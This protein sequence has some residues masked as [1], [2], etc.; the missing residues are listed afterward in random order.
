M[1]VTGPM[2]GADSAQ[3][4]DLAQRFSR[5]AA[6]L[7]GIDVRLT[8]SINGTGAWQ[9]GDAA[10][11]RSAWN[12]EHRAY[13][14]SSRTALTDGA[15]TLRRNAVEQDKASEGSGGA[16]GALPPV[17]TGT[18]QLTGGE[19]SGDILKVLEGLRSG[20]DWFQS[21]WN[22]VGM[23][24][25][26]D[27]AVEAGTEGLEDAVKSLASLRA[28]RAAAQS[29]L[30]AIEAMKSQGMEI[31]DS[32]AKEGEEAASLLART[33]DLESSLAAGIKSA[34]F[35]KALGGVSRVVDGAGVLADAL[36]IISPEDKGAMGWVD[37]GAAGVNGAL[38]VAN[39]TMDEIPVV[40]EVVMIGTGVY[41]AGDYLYHHWTAFRNVCNTVGNATADAAKWTWNEAGK[42]IDE[43]GHLASE[44]GHE[45]SHLAS[46]GLHAAGSAVHKLT[47]WL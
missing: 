32:V 22:I 41:L 8:A 35:L 31:L 1:I 21:G 20:N 42:G 16:T 13:L 17:L 37:R 39:M 18:A 3:L 34:G 36:T 33:G 7:Q 6:E 43:A 14:R 28:E 26:I 2:T 46:S 19:V 5:A 27:H 4:R 40:G 47:S 24:A 44:T 38:L 9:G 10:K 30:D 11:F 23:G 45:V 12:G 29:T 25:W 15:E